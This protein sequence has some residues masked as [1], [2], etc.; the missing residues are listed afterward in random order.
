MVAYLVML[1]CASQV[2]RA[3]GIRRRPPLTYGS[4]TTW[5]FLQVLF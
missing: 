2:G 3:Y 1:L 5:R 4:T